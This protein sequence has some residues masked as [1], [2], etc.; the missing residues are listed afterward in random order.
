MTLVDTPQMDDAVAAVKDARVLI[1]NP[2]FT[3][4]VKMGEKFDSDIQLALRH[5]MDRLDDLLMAADVELYEMLDPN[6]IE[7]RFTALGDLCTAR[8]VSGVTM[9]VPT[10]VL[11]ATSAANKRILLA[12]RFHIDTILTCH[13][14]DNINMSQDTAI[15]ESV[16]VMRRSVQ[17]GDTQIIS[18]DRYPCDD[19]EA[20]E[21]LSQIGGLSEGLIPNGW[22]EISQWPRDRIAAGDW[23]AAVWRSP[24]L[25]DAAARYAVHPQLK[26]LHTVGPVREAFQ[27]VEG[28]GSD[29]HLTIT[30]TPNA[31]RKNRKSNT[32]PI[33]KC[34][35]HLLVTAGQRTSTGRLTAMA[36]DNIFV[37]NGWSPITGLIPSEAKALAVFLNSTVGR[38]LLMRNPGKT[39]AFPAYE[40]AVINALPIPNIRDTNIQSVLTNCWSETC[41]VEVPQY[42]DG[43]IQV[44]QVWDEAVCESLGWDGDEIAYLGELLAAEPHVRGFARGQWKF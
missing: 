6:S 23:S 26:P 9:V 43:Y 44:R 7:P 29:D 41:D 10:T 2:P 17:P 19:F 11:S 31:Y 3:N 37:G 28:K 24:V 12:N 5:R 40:V 36:S 22:G 4:R 30:S 15:N 21:M 25:A 38:L 18:L 42:R 27:L 34:A 39:L 35:G 33:L 8:S 32:P 1:M 13:N 14:P 20:Q 16:V